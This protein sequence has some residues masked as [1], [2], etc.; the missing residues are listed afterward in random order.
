M[1]PHPAHLWTKAPALRLLIPFMAGILVQW[2]TPLPLLFL[3]IA[4]LVFLSIALLYRF[5]PLPKRF[6]LASL[7][8]IALSVLVGI[9]GAASLYT[10]D[11]R[12][13]RVWF[14]HHL[15]DS[16]A[17]VL[18]LEEPLVEKPAS[19]K[20]VATVQSVY[21]GRR[22]LPT[23]GKVI[24]YFKKD[25]LPPALQYG[26]Q[27]VTR[28]PLQP[29][30]N[31][32]NPGAFD[33]RRYNLFQGITHQVYLTPVE[34]YT[35]PRMEKSSFREGLFR[36]R[37]AIVGILQTY[38]TG[39][40]EQGLAEA[41]LIGYK[42]DL[43]KGLQLAY[44]NTGVVHV[45]AISGL[46]VG[47]IYGLLLLL[48][49]PLKRKGLRALRLLLLLAGLWSFGLLAGAGASVMRSVVMFSFLAGAEVLGRRAG[50]YNTMALSAFLLL[51]YHPFWLWDIGFQ[52]S[53]AAVISI[54]LFYG[55]IRRMIIFPNKAIDSIWKMIAVTLSAQ[56]FTTPLVLY[57]FHQ[58]PTL[59]L[60]TN[61]LAV[62]LSGL[63]LFGEILL[64][65]LAFLP[66]AAALLGR[67][68]SAMI[69][70]MNTYIERMDSV[71]FGVWGGISIS[72]V[73]TALLIIGLAAAAWWLLE[74]HREAV[75]VAAVCTV[76]FFILRTRSFQEAERQHK[77]IV[78]N[79][80]KHEAIDVI[81]G[82][83]CRFIGDAVV[84]QDP[85]L[86]SYHL[87]PS[88]V[89]HRLPPVVPAAPLQS[90]TW[91][92]KQVLIIDTTIRLK[93][94]SAQGKVDLL[95]LSG[96]PKVYMTE[97]VQ[98]FQPAQVVADASVPRWKAVLWKRDCTALG[99]PFYD[100]EEKGAFVLSP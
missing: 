42:D 74:R 6:A 83:D 38:I 41:L 52:L 21:K 24:L 32:G 28:K 82:R 84:Q 75:T 23:E 35:L 98:C 18:K 86:R 9:V 43:N 20:A 77:L 33:Y 54:L 8:G 61:L 27:L 31:S 65:L 44:S 49:H 88:R 56:V 58:F 78:Y 93:K 30:R 10:R 57:H 12:N 95:I 71:S 90:F 68:L 50:V 25:S 89:L 46:H 60:L 16:A 36:S 72:V 51:G 79:V 99:V 11:V 45:I 66:G 55:P 97:L 94:D 37:Q 47:L 70:F 80:P 87:Q 64:C 17:L 22:S 1:Q 34:Y 85:L 29:V 2:Y 4:G 91:S 81:E 39:P 76:L 40:K 48:T 19:W 3:I 26:S 96:N 14:G 100:V 53:Y 62:P 7:N 73:Q 67:L 69:H 59:F 63:I 15:S 92:G 5:L 13:S